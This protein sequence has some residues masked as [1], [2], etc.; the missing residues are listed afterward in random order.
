MAVSNGTTNNVNNNLV[1]NVIP[2]LDEYRLHGLA[3][4]AMVKGINKSD[5]IIAIHTAIDAELDWN[6]PTNTTSWVKAVSD[7][8]GD[9]H[10]Q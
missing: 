6:T 2:S 1:S 8:G 7:A 4:A 5:R 9:Q 3:C 10:I